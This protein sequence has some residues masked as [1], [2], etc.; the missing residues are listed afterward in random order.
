MPTF[1]VGDKVRVK[2][3]T[4]PYAECVGT[5]LSTDYGNNIEVE[6]EFVE[7]RKALYS[8]WELELLPAAQHEE[9]AK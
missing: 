5:I 4:G 6:F 1:K 3:D 7:T 9:R 2:A 8:D